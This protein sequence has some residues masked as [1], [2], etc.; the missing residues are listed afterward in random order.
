MFSTLR[1]TQ[2]ASKATVCIEQ[3]NDPPGQGHGQR[4]SACNHCRAK[5]VRSATHDPVT[6]SLATASVAKTNSH[7]WLVKHNS[8]M[9][10]TDLPLLQQLKCLGENKNSERKEGSFCDRCRTNGIKCVF[11]QPS[12]AKGSKRRRSTHTISRTSKKGASTPSPTSV[13]PSP[14]A[15]TSTTYEVVRDLAFGPT[16]DNQTTSDTI[17]EQFTGSGPSEH[18][19]HPNMAR[20]QSLGGHDD[21]PFLADHGN[22]PVHQFDFN[23]SMLSTADD[24][25]SFDFLADDS[26]EWPALTYGVHGENVYSKLQARPLAALTH[27]NIDSPHRGLQHRRLSHEP[28]SHNISR[29][30]LQFDVFGN[31]GDGSAI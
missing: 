30:L 22:D 3:A 11:P 5:K 1:Y 27:T 18:A 17:M 29:G 26:T 10:D 14:Q 31:L 16:G 21:Y 8:K 2:N 12:L 23:L 20:T 24:S 6:A 13:A 15:R 28:F 25:H 19:K 4:H 9:I 7:D